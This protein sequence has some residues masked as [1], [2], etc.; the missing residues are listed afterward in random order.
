M[1]LT[2][3]EKLLGLTMT[4]KTVVD[5]KCPDST[6]DDESS[7]E[8]AAPDKRTWVKPWR[9]GMSADSWERLLSSLDAQLAVLATPLNHNTGFFMACLRFLASFIVFF[10]GSRSTDPLLF[11]LWRFGK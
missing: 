8:D 7:G 11:V 6:L 5:N 1:V 9:S 4:D 2:E 10:I 3:E